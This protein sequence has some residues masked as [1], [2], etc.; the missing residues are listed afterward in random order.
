MTLGGI[1]ISVAS[2]QNPSTY[3]SAV[4]LTATVTP[5]TATGS[6]TFYD[7]ATA[8]GT[9]ALASGS[10]ALT[11]STLAV[12]AHSITALYP[13]SGT[14][15]AAIHQTVNNAGSSISLSSSANPSALNQS[16]NFTGIV[17]PS[18]CTGTVT[19]YSN[20]T[21]I[22]TGTV[23]NG[24]ATLATSW[25]SAGSRSMTA[26]Y[27]GDSNCSG[28]ST[29]P[30]A[31][32]EVVAA[33]TQS[34]VVLTSNPNAWYSGQT[35]AFTATVAPTPPNNETVTFYDGNASIGSA[36]TNGG[37]ATLSLNAGLATVGQHSITAV[38]PG[39]GTLSASTSNALVQNVGPYIYPTGLSLSQGPAQM[40]FVIS[41][42]GFP[43]PCNNCVTLNGANAPVVQ[44]PPTPN[45]TTSIT[46]QV[47]GNAGN[48]GP[49]VVAVNG[50]PSNGVPFT[51][52]G[53][54]GCQ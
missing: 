38:Y 26:S 15:S 31:L 52:I 51:V 8:L 13:T 36:P 3:A 20:G 12:G 41:G 10:A 1:N 22:G 27:G 11:V 32:A 53:G 29:P 18:L 35:I 7:G 28:S 19:F 16:V 4:T 34:S 33:L 49:V 54:F 9:V 24:D 44:N 30:P 37:V 42:L 45:G 25:G 43:A 2:S 48:G 40:G 5:S 17:A 50:I 23:S 47:P 6:V 39:D 14:T 21:S 46:V